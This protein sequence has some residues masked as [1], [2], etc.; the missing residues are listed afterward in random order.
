MFEHAH[1]RKQVT[2]AGPFLHRIQARLNRHFEERPP[3]LATTTRPVIFSQ[4][5]V[6]MRQTLKTGSMRLVT[7]KT[8]LATLDAFLP[9][10][11]HFD[12]VADLAALASV[13]KKEVNV[14]PL[15]SKNTVLHKLWLERNHSKF[16]NH[17]QDI[18]QD[19][20]IQL[21]AWQS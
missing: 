4:R 14:K 1:G 11:S 5:V 17:F 6:R 9:Y 2:K 3:F 16:R 13:H 15:G 19:R 12:Y 18:D 21:F 8:R 10:E 7:A 20:H